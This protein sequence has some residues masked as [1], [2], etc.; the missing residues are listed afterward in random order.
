MEISRRVGKHLEPLVGD[1][2]DENKIREILTM[3]FAEK[4]FVEW[5]RPQFLVFDKDYNVVWSWWWVDFNWSDLASLQTFLKGLNIDVVSISNIITEMEQLQDWEGKDSVKLI[6]SSDW[7]QTYSIIFKRRSLDQDSWEERWTLQATIA[8]ASY[9]SSL[10]NSYRQ[11][12]WELVWEFSSKWLILDEKE[13]MDKLLDLVS[14]LR[15]QEFFDLISTSL[16]EIKALIYSIYDIS[17][18]TEFYVDDAPLFSQKE[19]PVQKDQP[20]WKETEKMIDDIIEWNKEIPKDIMDQ[21]LDIRKFIS[22]AIPTFVIAPSWIEWPVFVLNNE[23]IWT[24]DNFDSFIKSFQFEGEKIDEERI[25]LLFWIEWSKNSIMLWDKSYIFASKY[26]NSINWR[27]FTLTPNKNSVA[28]PLSKSRR[29]EV[30]SDSLMDIVNGISDR[31][32][33]MSVYELIV[34]NVNNIHTLLDDIVNISEGQGLEKLK[35]DLLTDIELFQKNLSQE[36][37]TWKCVIITEDESNFMY[38]WPAYAISNV[39]SLLQ[40]WNLNN[41]LSDIGINFSKDESYTWINVVFSWSLI[42]DN[43]IEKITE[44]FTS[45]NKDLDIW[46]HT[47]LFN[48]LIELISWIEWWA[49]KVEKSK[50]WVLFS[51]TMK[52][53]NS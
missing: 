47:N 28:D 5:A 50:E 34:Q 6:Q 53:I 18:W 38:K 40:N 2:K 27:Q 21:I 43:D 29:I 35:Q 48:D 1:I 11:T 30:L 13:N 24:Y 25:K 32:G 45:W 49:I 10:Y 37:V 15:S 51:I 7:S 46:E 39:L 9:F 8:E 12:A 31:E 14:E 20:D 26:S 42:S 52:S 4:L 36:W 17:R 19:V 33:L 16:D 3:A 22:N 41:W 44:K 23:H